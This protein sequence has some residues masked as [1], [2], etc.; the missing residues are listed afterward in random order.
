MGIIYSFNTA[1]G[2]I[3]IMARLYYLFEIRPFAGTLARALR[4]EGKVYL[5]DFTRIENPGARF[6]NLVALHLLKL[7]D[8]WNDWGYGDFSLHYIRDKEKREADFLITAS[9]KPYALMEA[10]LSDGQVDPSL[11]Y[12]MAR[13]KPRFCL[14]IVRRAGAQSRGGNGQPHVVAASQFLSRI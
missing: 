4:R 1:R 11:R 9:G 10:K 13:L 8:A 3:E 5:Y 14:Q 6:E 2:W 7:C 12:Y